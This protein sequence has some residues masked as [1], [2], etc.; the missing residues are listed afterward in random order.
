MSDHEL[1]LKPVLR[2]G[3]TL[4]DIKFSL[5]HAVEAKPERHKLIEGQSQKGRAMCQLGG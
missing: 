2:N 5:L 1:D 3:G 4:K